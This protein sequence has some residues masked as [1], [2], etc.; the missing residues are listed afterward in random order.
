[1][2]SWCISSRPRGPLQQAVTVTDP[3]MHLILRFPVHDRMMQR[4]RMLP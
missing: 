2:M 4:F 1:M 3:L